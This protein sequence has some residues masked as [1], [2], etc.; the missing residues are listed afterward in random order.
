MPALVHPEVKPWPPQK[1][2]EHAL[3]WAPIAILDLAKWDTPGGK[4]SLARDLNDAVRNMG[5]WVV[6]NSGI[7]QEAMDRQFDLANTFFDL[8]LEEKIEVT[9]EED[10]KSYFGYRP[11]GKIRNS[12]HKENLEILNI[13]KSVPGT[14][15]PR[16]AFIARH[17]EEITA[18]Q[19]LVHETVICKLFIL[20]AIMLELPENHFVNMHIFEEQSDDHMRF[21]KYQPRTV[22]EDKAVN[23]QWMAGHTDFGSITLLFP[24]PVAGLQV[25]TPE[26]DWKW[27]KYVEGGITCNA[28]DLLSIMTKGYVKSAV[29][30]VVRPPPDQAHM[31]RLG[32]FFFIRPMKNVR[33]T[34]SAS[35]VLRREGLW[36]EED[37]EFPIEEAATC[38]EFIKARM[39]TFDLSRA[40]QT[41]D[42]PVVRVKN[43]QV[44]N[45]Y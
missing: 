19:K 41:K 21:I 17:E 29:H 9:F 44:L 33:I 39:Q 42:N 18:F 16:H 38:E 14:N 24:Q 8:P 26:N 22:E 28:A 25:R 10:G 4:E 37:D 1:P 11:P 36:K 45:E 30:R 15:I 35:P 27:V 5:F 2:T 43:L 32:F 20:F 13:H 34:P 23:D 12:V 7:P 40:P 31:Q 6:V 3:D